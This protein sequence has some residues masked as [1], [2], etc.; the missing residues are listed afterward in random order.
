MWGKVESS[1]SLLLK[2]EPSLIYKLLFLLTVG[3]DL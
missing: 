1:T 2:S 3:F